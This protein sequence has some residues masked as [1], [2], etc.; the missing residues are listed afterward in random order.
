MDAR[1]NPVELGQDVVW[2]IE[3][4]VR[5]DVALDPGEDS[6]GRQ[7]LVCLGD[8]FGLPAD[9]VR[10]EPG[11]RADRRRVIADC[12]VFVAEVAC[13]QP[14][15]GDGL[16]SVRPGRVAVEVAADLVE[17]DEPRWLPAEGA[18]AQLR[19]AE[20]ESELRING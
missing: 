8:F 5:P 16:A 12:E 15:R 1:L 7:P 9:I 6:E 13:G 4:A 14:R 17:R 2:E 11:H 18:L 19:R 10:P 3:L 20:R